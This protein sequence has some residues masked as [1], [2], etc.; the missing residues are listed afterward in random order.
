[1]FPPPL[2]GAGYVKRKHLCY[3][4]SHKD[5]ASLPDH[6]QISQREPG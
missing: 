5:P 3:L 4:P 6:K 1:M 2:G